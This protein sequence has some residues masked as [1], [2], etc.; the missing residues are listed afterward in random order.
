MKPATREWIE[1][2]NKVTSAYLDGLAGRDK[3][4]SRLTEIWNYECT[5]KSTNC[6][7][8]AAISNDQLSGIK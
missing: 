3:I 5:R 8:K 4:K 7:P 6:G 1:A 2:E